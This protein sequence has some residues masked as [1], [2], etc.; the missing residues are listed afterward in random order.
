MKRRF[1]DILRDYMER[2]ELVRKNKNKRE[3]HL[4]EELRDECDDPDVFD[5]YNHMVLLVLN[6]RGE[7]LDSFE[8]LVDKAIELWKDIEG[9]LP[10]LT[11]DDIVNLVGR[12]VG[13]V[14]YR[15]CEEIALRLGEERPLRYRDIR[16]I[17]RRCESFR[18]ERGSMGRVL[19][20]VLGYLERSGLLI[21]T[22]SSGRRISFYFRI[23]RT[24]RPDRPDCSS[25]RLVREIERLLEHYHS[26]ISGVRVLRRI[27]VKVAGNENVSPAP[28]P[29]K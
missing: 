11:G 8:S 2:G 16:E 26:A 4:P 7:R 10:V 20:R 18:I 17:A 9:E 3:Y 1:A 13:Y 27:P 22:W 25:C 5:K 14:D 28:S 21:K 6:A 24:L 23:Y 15:K 12:H 19:S 29:L